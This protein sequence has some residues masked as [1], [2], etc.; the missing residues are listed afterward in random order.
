VGLT[1][2]TD[3]IAIIVSEETGRVSLAVD[4]A[5]MRGLD[6]PKLSRLL[7]EYYLEQESREIV[8]E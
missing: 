8:T 7:R 5:I 4:G 6:F 1:E 3:A 2:E